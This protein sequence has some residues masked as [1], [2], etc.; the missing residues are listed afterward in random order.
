M[1]T[2]SQVASATS[3]AT[4]V[5]GPASIIAGDLL[6]LLDMAFNATL[7]ASTVPSGF[8][9]IWDQN[10]TVSQ[11]TIMSYKIATGAEASASLTGMAGSALVNK[12]LY[13]FRG[14]SAIAA[15]S[16][17]D[18]DSQFTSGNPTAQ[19]IT[20]GSGVA[21]LVVLAGYSADTA[22]NPRTFTV[23]GVAAKDGELAHGV[24]AYLAYKIYNAAPANVVIDMDD[25]GGSNNLGGCYIQVEFAETTV[26][27]AASSAGAA[28]ATATANSL[29]DA[30]VSSAGTASAIA[31]AES[32]FDAV[33]QSSG[34]STASSVGES[35]ADAEVYSE[36]SSVAEA[37]G[38]SD[39]EIPVD[40][41][42][43]VVSPLA[44]GGGGVYFDPESLRFKVKKPRKP[45]VFTLKIGEWPDLPDPEDPTDT[46][47]PTICPLICICMQP[48][49]SRPRTTSHQMTTSTHW[50]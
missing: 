27:A 36:G 45:R 2:I 12:Q 1:A 16:V 24:L 35:F 21:P 17:L 28:S 7:P 49:P 50:T 30:I 3:A 44:G 15:V 33:A 48:M 25:E 22:I 14:D 19:T 26:D 40:N 37:V 13:V 20:S 39:G 11:R 47:D 9:I 18:V 42:S 6:V 46:D 10:D 5:T 4:T 23:G 8:T 41:P 34:F 29:V 43:D 31:V 32:L 38:D